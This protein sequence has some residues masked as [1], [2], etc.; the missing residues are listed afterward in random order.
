MILA[1]ACK[2]STANVLEL[3]RHHNPYLEHA[4]QRHWPPTI[5]TVLGTDTKPAAVKFLF[6]MLCFQS[7]HKA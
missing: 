2:S 7:T 1:A 6:Q 3:V 4:F 5:P